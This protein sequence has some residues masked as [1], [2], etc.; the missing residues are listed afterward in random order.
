MRPAAN[1]LMTCLLLL[2]AV[3][4][5]CC[6]SAAACSAC[7]ASAAQVQKHAACCEQCRQDS[8][9]DEAP[10]CPLEHR[11]TCHGFCTFLK[12]DGAS[13]AGCQVALFA[14]TAPSFEPLQATAQSRPIW[15]ACPLEPSPPL[16]LHV[17]YQII[18]I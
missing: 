16:R 14:F 11:Q 6:H 5:V 15:S 10:A 18:L 3:F 7:R 17:L 1:Y 4:G 12:A 9:D 13:L 2:Q 8:S